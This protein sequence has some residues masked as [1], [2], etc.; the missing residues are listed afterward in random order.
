MKSMEDEVEAAKAEDEAWRTWREAKAEA[1]TAAYLAKA[2]AAYL[3]KAEDEAWEVWQAA[4]QTL[5]S[6]Q[7]GK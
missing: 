6:N 7:G 2:E 5:G 1:D 4:L 3:A